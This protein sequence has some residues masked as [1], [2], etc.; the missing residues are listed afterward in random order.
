MNEKLNEKLF[1][2]IERKVNK[3]EKLLLKDDEMSREKNERLTQ[4]L[5]NQSDVLK[6]INMV[7]YYLE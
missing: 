4:L 2:R 1:E 6:Q 7:M 3:I 5:E